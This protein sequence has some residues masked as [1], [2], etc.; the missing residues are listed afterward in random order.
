MKNRRRPVRKEGA[1]SFRTPAAWLGAPGV[2]THY[3]G[4]VFRRH[5]RDAQE[6]KRIVG[7]G[8]QVFDQ[9][10]SQADEIEGALA[11]FR[12][13]IHPLAVFQVHDA[14][15]HRAGNWREAIVGVT[16]EDSGELTLLRDEQ[17]LDQL[18]QRKPG[19]VDEG[20][21]EEGALRRIS[22]DSMLSWLEQAREHAC[23]RVGDL[24]LPFRKT[25]VNDLALFWPESR[26]QEW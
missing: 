6:A 17:V 16:V 13:G 19:R 1:F 24:R 5:P 11:L 9:A 22:S 8:H 23:E 26:N 14:V 20:V 18:N 15:T 10:L 12:E 21:D 3:E 25:L 7:V 4:L 2:R